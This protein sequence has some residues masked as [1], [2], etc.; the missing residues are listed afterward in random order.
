MES[1]LSGGGE[2]VLVRSESYSPSWLARSSPPSSGSGGVDGDG[3]RGCGRLVSTVSCP[4]REF[5]GSDLTERTGSG[6]LAR[7]GEVVICGDGGEYGFNLSRFSSLPSSSS[8][9]SRRLG[10]TIRSPGQRSVSALGGATVPLVSSPVSFPVEGTVNN[11][12]PTYGRSGGFRGGICP[13]EDMVLFLLLRDNWRCVAKYDDCVGGGFRILVLHF[14]FHNETV[15][16][17]KAHFYR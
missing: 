1:W 12:G 11:S 7:G 5:S 15:G 6:I 3:E 16:R 10:C 8:E 9:E 4:P 2:T 17:P 13:G 14:P